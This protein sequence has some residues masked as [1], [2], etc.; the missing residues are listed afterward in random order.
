MIIYHDTKKELSF[1]DY[2][3][4]TMDVKK[5]SFN[6]LK[7]LLDNLEQAQ[8]NSFLY[9]NDLLVMAI[10]TDIQKVKMYIKFAEKRKA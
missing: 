2:K 1:S 4:V 3:P 6:S 8:E 9:G 5:Q 10:E 7:Q